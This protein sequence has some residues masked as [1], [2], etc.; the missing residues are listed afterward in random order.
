MFAF[1]AEDG[2]TLKNKVPRGFVDAWKRFKHKKWFYKIDDDTF[3][4]WRNL[5]KALNHYDWR[6]VQYIGHK[7]LVDCN[8]TD[9]NSFDSTS[10]L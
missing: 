7:S 1:V 6:Q 9:S 10:Y 8:G 3:V 2:H 5:L 4:V